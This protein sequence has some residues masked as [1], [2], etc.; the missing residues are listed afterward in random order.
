MQRANVDSC[1]STAALIQQEQKILLNNNGKSFLGS[2]EFSI[3]NKEWIMFFMPWYK[4]GDLFQ[5]WLGC[6]SYDDRIDPYAA[7]FYA[8]ELVLAVDSLH[9]S[10]YIHRDIKLENLMIAEDG[11]L[12]LVDFG[13]CHKIEPSCDDPYCDEVSDIRCGT[14]VYAPPEMVMGRRYGRAAD[15]WAVGVVIYELLC[16]APP[17]HPTES[18]FHDIVYY[19]PFGNQAT[20]SL[21]YSEMSLLMGLLEK[22]PELRLGY[23]QNG[24]AKIKGHDFF[25]GLDWEALEAKKILPPL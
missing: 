3:Q 22:E 10:G 16:N 11:H 21:G 1:D 12:V 20:N 6:E 24:V 19:E 17:F 25:R 8:A 7:R 4:G 13:I 14:P 9:Q 23:G 2:M 5:M 18:L 15:W